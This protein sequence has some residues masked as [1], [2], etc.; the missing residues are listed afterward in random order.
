A[1]TPEH[2]D[3]AHRNDWQPRRIAPR[4]FLARLPQRLL[5]RGAL[6][7]IGHLERAWAYSF[8]W[9]D[10]A[11]VDAFESTLKLLLD[12]WP[13][14]AT[15]E[16]FNQRYA[17]LATLLA[18]ALGRAFSGEPVDAREVARLWTAHNDAR[19]YVVVGDPAVRL[20]C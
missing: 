10:A 5:E 6:A 12:G 18:T 8:L 11:Q 1:G 13:V 19:G 15:M 7:V 20:A 17:E 3:F 2:D 16:Y 4:D 9:R 14:G